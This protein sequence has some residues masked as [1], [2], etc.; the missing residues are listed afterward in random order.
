MDEAALLAAAPRAKRYAIYGQGV[1]LIVNPNGSK[2][3]RMNV[4]RNGI[5]TTLSLG[6]FPQT[7]IADALAEHERI[8]SQARM[9]IHPVAARRAARE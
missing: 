4:R 9:D 3:W 1:Y 5:N 2:W 6:T 7:S 8:R